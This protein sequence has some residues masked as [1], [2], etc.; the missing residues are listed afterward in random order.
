M[1]GKCSLS[2]LKRRIA[3]RP[4]A[5]RSCDLRSTGRTFLPSWRFRSQLSSIPEDSRACDGIDLTLKT[6]LDDRPRLDEHPGDGVTRGSTRMEIFADAVFAIAFTLPMVEI[7]LPEGRSDLGRQLL[8]LWPSY[9]GYALSTLVI[10][11][12]WVQHHFAGALFRTTGHRFLAATLIFVSAIAFIAIP[13]RAFA[14]HI[15]DPIDRVVGAQFYAVALAATSV[16]WW[17]SWRTAR[18]TGDLDERLDAAYVIRLD[19]HY[20]RVTAA[21][22]VAAILVFFSWELGLALAG[23]ITLYQLRPPETPIYVDEAP[24]IEEEL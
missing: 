14:E 2:S 5:G 16:T 18:V 12:Y 19:Q 21:M 17:F 15:Q 22:V 10:G 20:V 24:V 8:A 3:E 7:T 23:A 9:L 4:H 1:H 6:K 11:T 13:T